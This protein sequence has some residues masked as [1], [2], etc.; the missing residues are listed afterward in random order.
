PSKLCSTGQKA[1]SVAI[2]DFNNDGKPDLAVVNL[3]NKVNI[4]IGVGDGTFRP[5]KQY[6]VGQGTSLTGVAVGD[7][8]EDG[9]IDVITTV[10]L[11]GDKGGSIALLRGRGDGTFR[12]AKYIATQNSPSSVVPADFNGDHHLDL[13]VAGNGSGSVLLGKGDGT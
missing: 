5:R 8:N 4:L 10:S 13:W 1:F 11:T 7:F 2:A 6:A 9:N 3:F 12:P